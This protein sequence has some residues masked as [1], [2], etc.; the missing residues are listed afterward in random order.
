MKR[1]ALLIF[2]DPVGLD[3][4]RRRWPR[5]LRPLLSVPGLQSASSDAD[6]HLFSSTQPAVLPGIRN[7]AQHGA[8]F[9][10]RLETAIEKIGALGYEEA[11]I[12]GSDCPS[13]HPSDIAEAF[14]Q[15]REKRLVLGPDHR[16]GCYLIALRLDD[17][18]LLEGIRWNRDT[19]RAQLCGRLAAREIALLAVKQDVDTW[20]D[21]R[22][23][24]RSGHSLARLAIVLFQIGKTTH[25]FFVDLTAQNVRVRGQMPP[26]AWAR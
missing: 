8:T 2:A 10:E 6:F 5:F 25:E 14:T 17:R 19:D 20:A 9:D 26:P 11:V 23:L 18:A 21:L 7:H 16:G 1:K 3:L 24:A 13:L 15:L 12:V 4:A 22:L